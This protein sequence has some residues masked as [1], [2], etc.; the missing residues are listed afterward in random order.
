MLKSQVKHSIL[1]TKQT[2]Q[3]D[4]HMSDVEKG[5]KLYSEFLNLSYQEL[6]ALVN[7]AKDTLEHEFY[8]RL[9]NFYLY[10]NQPRVMK[11]KPF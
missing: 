5:K 4:Q 7:E 11:E 3:G 10:A 2:M 1:G 6:E 9:C 8:M